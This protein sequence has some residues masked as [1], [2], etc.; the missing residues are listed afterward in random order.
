MHRRELHIKKDMNKPEAK[1]RAQ[2]LREEINDLRYRYHVLDDP[3]VTDEVYDSLT[4]EL[5]KIEKEFPSQ[6]TFSS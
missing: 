3:E 2:K 1:I 5:R 4:Q 6:E